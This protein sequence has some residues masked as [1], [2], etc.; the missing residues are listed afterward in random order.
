MLWAP[1][2]EL[3]LGS[4]VLAVDV[5]ILVSAGDRL[6]PVLGIEVPDFSEEPQSLTKHTF[7]MFSTPALWPQAMFNVRYHFVKIKLYL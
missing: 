7:S 6:V 3:I 2:W 5:A 4:E 1:I